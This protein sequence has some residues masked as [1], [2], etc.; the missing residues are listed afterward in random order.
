[1]ASA[2]AGSNWGAQGS[3][4]SQGDKAYD[5][6]IYHGIGATAG[7]AETAGTTAAGTSGTAAGETAASAGAGTGAAAS[8]AATGA[9]GAAST[10]EA[11]GTKSTALDT[12]GSQS[13]G[14]SSKPNAQT[15][16]T[17]GE[18]E[19]GT[20]Q[21]AWGS[22]DQSTWQGSS[23]QS[24]NSGAS[25]DATSTSGS[26]EAQTNGQSQE[27]TQ[28]EASAQG[29]TW[30]EG[31]TAQG[32]TDAQQPAAQNSN[33]NTNT[34]SNALDSGS[35]GSVQQSPG[36]Y[37]D[38]MWHGDNN[39]ES[40][41]NQSQSNTQ[42]NTNAPNQ[43]STN[44]GQWQPN[45]QWQSPTDAST[46]TS[47][48]TT[49]SATTSPSTK[50]SDLPVHEPTALP[51]TSES[52]RL[53]P[54]SEA[55]IAVGVM[56]LV[57][58]LLGL[59]FFRLHRKK[60]ALQDQMR[61][62]KNLPPL[63]KHNP[64]YSL[65]SHLYTKSSLTLVGIS[66]AFKGSTNN[67]AESI[68]NEATTT[69]QTTNRRSITNGPA[70]ANESTSTVN[71]TITQLPPPVLFTG[72]LH[73]ALRKPTF[74]ARAQRVA[75]HVVALV[76]AAASYAAHKVRG[77]KKNKLTP[78]QRR[79]LQAHEYGFSEEFL[80]IPPPPEQTRRLPRVL[81]KV[82]A[83]GSLTVRT[84]TQKLNRSQ[85]SLGRPQTPSQSELPQFQT[86]VQPQT[87]IQPPPPAQLQQQF[88]CQCQAQHQPEPEPQPKARPQ[89]QSVAKANNGMSSWGT[90]TSIHS[91]VKASE[92]NQEQETRFPLP[93]EIIG[94]ELFR[95]RSVSCGTV[96]MK[97][98]AA[99]ISIDALA[100]RI[101]ED[102]QA[103]QAE[104]AAQ[105]SQQPES[106]P[107]PQP[108]PQSLSQSRSPSPTASSPTAQPIPVYQPAQAEVTSFKPSSITVYRIDMPFR[109]CSTGQLEVTEGMLVRLDQAFDD[110][111][112][113]CK[114]TDTENR[115]L[116]PRACLST[117]PQ[118]DSR[119]YAPSISDPHLGNVSSASLPIS[120]VESVAQS[121]R[122]YRQHSRSGTPVISPA[123]STNLRVDSGYLA[124]PR[125]MGESHGIATTTLKNYSTSR[126][127][128]VTDRCWFDL[129]EGNRV[130]LRIAFRRTERVLTFNQVVNNQWTD[131]VR[132]S[133][134]DDLVA[135]RE[136]ALN[137]SYENGVF[138]V[139]FNDVGAKLAW[140]APADSLEY[141]ADHASD[142][143][144]RDWVPAM[145][146]WNGS[147]FDDF[148]EK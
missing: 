41:N 67:S 145:Y 45:Q 3:Q 86:E 129:F 89:A 16:S 125:A 63:D 22:L 30:G 105:P 23:K 99:N 34:N 57:L 61:K 55:G 66:E 130:C 35:Q 76:T 73:P 113:L 37:D 141:R 50:S 70:A 91:L 36:G 137:I 119:S 98:P 2:A 122:F 32:Q 9:A 46:E 48:T 103:E 42:G 69:V 127:G 133:F 20:N 1:M 59:I 19:A 110:G 139:A 92:D 126:I 53:S 96:A 118:K 14:S 82:H 24:W 7:T 124:F 85:T 68:P 13:A 26:R 29:Q 121:F 6:G 144:F 100:G 116:I 39:V 58:L 74:K 102:E 60:R 8:G 101:S 15:G 21:A 78:A 10:A 108:Q 71:S 114:I 47:S 136:I 72:D 27:N 77:M 134:P 146:G 44:S 38:G 107:E 62:E 65:A 28:A 25:S 75:G 54:G 94:E 117:W 132:Y 5:D 17:A 131:E 56:A 120:P 140:G 4:V 79:S 138:A 51:P 142:A 95:V 33:W 109:P 87:P 143:I 52:R 31:Q 106:Q 148:G 40:T 128:Y 81:T 104:Q 49:S 18:Q 64:M 123:M 12:T 111:W 112:A 97:N 90:M 115:G 43:D 88:V 135:G 147:L 93:C 80:H 84:L 11:A 83:S